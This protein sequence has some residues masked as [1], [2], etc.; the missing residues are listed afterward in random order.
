MDS[1]LIFVV[2]L[3]ELIALQLEIGDATGANTE[4]VHQFHFLLLQVENLLRGLFGNVVPL[5][6]GQ[7][8]LL[9]G[10]L[11]AVEQLGD[12]RVLLFDLRRAIDEILLHRLVVL[13]DPLNVRQENAGLHVRRAFRLE[14]TE[15]RQ[16]TLVLRTT[17]YLLA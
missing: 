8:T 10:T 6:A 11:I 15:R 1:R 14:L 13:D 5:L 4:V 16:S 7:V 3:S 2:R 9:D 12:L 17:L